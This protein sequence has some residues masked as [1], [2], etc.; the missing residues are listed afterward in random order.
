LRNAP[1]EEWRRLLTKDAEYYSLQYGDRANEAA[2]LG[3]ARHDAGAIHNLDRLAAMIKSC[4]LVVTVCQTNVHLA[5]A[6]DVPCLCLVPAKPAWRYGLTGDKMVWYD[7]VRLLR[8]AE[9]EPWPE[10]IERARVL[11]ADF[12]NL[13]RSEKAAA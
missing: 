1:V 7:S 3:V 6:L 13:Q 10:V 11:I 5:G 4:D 8:Q 2:K 9:G 12:R